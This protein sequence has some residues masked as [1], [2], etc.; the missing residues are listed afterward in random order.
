MLTGDFRNPSVYKNR[1]NQLRE[2]EQLASPQ[3]TVAYNMY[4]QNNKRLARADREVEESGGI[5]PEQRT[6]APA[7]TEATRAMV[8]QLGCLMK[9]GEG[10]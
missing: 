9:D 6:I 3:R 1:L 5:P 4:R 2:M 7:T 10:D 8:S